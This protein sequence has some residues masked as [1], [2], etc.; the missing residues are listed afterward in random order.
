MDNIKTRTMSE[1]NKDFIAEMDPETPY[2]FADG[3]DEA[4]IGTWSEK[5]VY[6]ENKCVEV[7][8]KTQEWDYETAREWFDFNIA[9]AYVGE[10]TPIFVS[11]V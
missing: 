7:L 11:D 10:H 6:S 4:I 2:M 5:V 3:L 1:P 9:C 8:M